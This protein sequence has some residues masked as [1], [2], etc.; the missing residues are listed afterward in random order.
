MIIVIRDRRK[1]LKKDEPEDRKS[2]I[3]L[4]EKRTTYTDRGPA[5]G[6]WEGRG[7]G[8]GGKLQE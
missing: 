6:R 7:G 1:F 3:L 8:E 4:Y 2:G 5:R